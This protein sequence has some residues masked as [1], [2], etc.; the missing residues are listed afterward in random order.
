MD[1]FATH[2]LNWFDHHGRHDLPWQKPI[3]PYRVWISE[4]MLQQTQVSTVIPYFER[5]M[6]RFPNVETLGG[7]PLDEVLHLWTGLGYY[8]RARNLHKAAIQIV[9][10]FEGGLPESLDQLES[11]PGIG[12]STAGAIRAIG[13]SKRA[14]ILDANVKRV[15]TRFHAISGF[16]GKTV[17]TKKLWDVSESH[18]PNTRLPDYTQAIMDLGATLCVRKLPNCNSCPLHTRC[19]ANAAGETDKYPEAKPAK[20]KPVRKCRMFLL[21]NTRDEFFLEQRP[22]EG[23]WGGLWSP[24]QREADY[25]GIQ[26][27]DELNFSAEGVANIGTSFRHTFTHYHLDIEPVM[28]RIKDGQNRVSSKTNHVWYS[29]NLNLKLGLSSAAVKLLSLDEP[30]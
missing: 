21:Q 11:L 30:G 19:K 27:L 7:A 5:F 28:I 25:S 12:R 22:P 1:W 13:H 24:P 4:I 15:L 10:K 14:P 26:M 6:Q 16:P 29:K 18:T 9:Q 23:I 17:I 8:A 20:V 3:Q 2:L